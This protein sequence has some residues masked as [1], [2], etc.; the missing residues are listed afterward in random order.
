MSYDV[1]QKV[2]DLSKRS[3]LVASSGKEISPEFARSLMIKDVITALY[4]GGGVRKYKEVLHDLIESLS[5]ADFQI[6]FI[7][8]KANGELK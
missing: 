2:V 6:A 4:E 7:K 5:D 1:L 3:Y 8:Y